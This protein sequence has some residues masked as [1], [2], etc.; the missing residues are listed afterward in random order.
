[1][2]F[3]SIR[4]AI[5]YGVNRVRFVSPVRAG[6]RIRAR[7]TPAAVE[8]THDAVQV[9]WAVTIEREHGTKPCVIAE[10]IVRYYL[11]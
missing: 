3:P 9:T 4:M 11:P 5:N 7:F 1:M 10:W 8:N 6:S 2:T